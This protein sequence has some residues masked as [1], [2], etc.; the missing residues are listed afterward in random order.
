MKLH[1]I[2]VRALTTSAAVVRDVTPEQAGLSTPCHEWDVRALTHHLLLVV[3]ALEMAGH[4]EPIADEHWVSPS[5]RSFDVGAA[6]AWQGPEPWQRPVR[7]GGTPMPAD[8][9]VAM[10]VSDVAIHGWDLARATGQEYRVDDGVAATTLRFVTTMGE[11]GRAMGIF[12]QPVTV[13][14]DVS[15]F[16][17][18]LALSGRNPFH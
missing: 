18:A 2:M 1:D 9:A 5:A 6:D 4:G 14:G 7:M 15:T 10:L 8:M 16:D 3:E 13:P 12:A 17:R 11:Q